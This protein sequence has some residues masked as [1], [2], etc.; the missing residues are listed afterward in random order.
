MSELELQLQRL[1]ADVEW[2]ATPSFD[3]RVHA[4]RRRWPVA[5]A[6]AAAL[7]VGL[8]FAVPQSRSALLRFFHIGAVSVER[9]ETLPPADERPLAASLGA[10][11]SQAEAAELL[12]RPFA[13]PDARVYR[14]GR[15][16]STILSGQLLFT[17]IRT[18]DDPVLLKKLASGATHVDWVPLGADI[19]ALWIHGGRHVFLAPAIPA[20]YAGN[21]LLWQA[22]GITYRLEGAHVRLQPALEIARDVLR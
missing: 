4:Q 16:V 8:A 21:T 14:S 12:G 18:G 9:V 20:R 7:A 10:E 6:L 17:E 19:P 1:A 2:P 15:S 22:R 3:L 11:I 13:F 5:V